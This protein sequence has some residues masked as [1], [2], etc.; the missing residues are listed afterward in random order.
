MYYTTPTVTSFLS[1]LQW[2]NQLTGYLFG[3]L[4]I[5]ALFAVI[6]L[7]LKRYGTEQAFAASSFVSAVVC[8]L[9]FL[10]DLTTVQHVVLTG[11]AVML[12]I[13]VL[14]FSEGGI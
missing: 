3:P 4:T 12:S 8:F 7:A 1:I 14:K 9:L 2:A 10:L 13:F 6:F 11:I 5:L